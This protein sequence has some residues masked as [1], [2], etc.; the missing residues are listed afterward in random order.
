MKINCKEIWRLLIIIINYNNT[1]K[2]I[3]TISCTRMAEEESQVSSNQVKAKSVIED[4]SLL[5]EHIWISYELLA[6][7]ASASKTMIA[8]NTFTYIFLTGWMYNRYMLPSPLCFWDLLIHTV[9][10]Y[11]VSASGLAAMCT[12]HGLALLVHV[13]FN[14]VW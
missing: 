11:W 10:E 9:G 5:L 6:F 1:N 4:V 12:N 14:L 8:I 13:A 3:V 7:L 2:F